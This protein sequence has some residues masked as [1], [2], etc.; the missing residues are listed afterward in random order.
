MTGG[1]AH[2]IIES[3]YSKHDTRVLKRNRCMALEHTATMSV[4]EYFRLE[5]TNPDTRYEYL[6][7][8]VYMMAGGSANHATIGGNIYAI[9][10]SLLRG[11]PCR[12]YNSD[13]KVRASETR[14]F[15]P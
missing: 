6:D 15:H 10:K 13:M 11:G 4:A 2:V 9:L 5:E 12:A 7:G 8:Y 1:V 3:I 14:Y